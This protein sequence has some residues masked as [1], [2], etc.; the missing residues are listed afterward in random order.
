MSQYIGNEPE[1]IDR[2]SLV[3][4]HPPYLGSQFVA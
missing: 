1:V 4:V 2:R 3:A